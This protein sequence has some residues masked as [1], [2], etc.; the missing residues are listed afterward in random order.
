MT[1]VRDNRPFPQRSEGAGRI[2]LS[3]RRVAKLQRCGLAIANGN[4]VPRLATTIST[5]EFLNRFPWV[6]NQLR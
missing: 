5:Y 6:L 2:V 4:K 3:G 1:Q